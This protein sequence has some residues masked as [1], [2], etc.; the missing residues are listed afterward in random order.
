MSE[1]IKRIRLTVENAGGVARQG[2]P[3][4][5]GVPFAEG[6]LKKGAPVRVVD[7]SGKAL[8]A[9]SSCLGTWGKDLK[10]VKWL[11]VDFQ[12]DLRANQTE[13]FFL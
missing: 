9:Q 8:A 11:L 5:Q 13:Q 1:R 12:A 4:T 7:A 6:D 3:I 10:D 2:W